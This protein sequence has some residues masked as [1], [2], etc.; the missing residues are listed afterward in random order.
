[1]LSHSGGAKPTG[2]SSRRRLFV[3][4]CHLHRFTRSTS[5]IPLDQGECHCILSHPRK[6][7]SKMCSSP[8]D[9][10]ILMTVQEIAAQNLVISR[11]SLAATTPLLAVGSHPVSP[12]V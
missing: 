3:Q 9:A 6:H 2:L 12:A 1:V 4:H 11:T 10:H 5:A 8:V 7:Q